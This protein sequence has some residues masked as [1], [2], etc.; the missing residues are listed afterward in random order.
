MGNTNLSLEREESPGVPARAAK[1]V[2][3][4]FRTFA[5]LVGT[6][7]V[8]GFSLLP[9]SA[10]LVALPAVAPG[11]A[12][13]TDTVKPVRS[14]WGRAARRLLAG[15]AGAAVLVALLAFAIELVSHFPLPTGGQMGT[16]AKKVL[17]YS[18]ADFV[19]NDPKPADRPPLKGALDRRDAA[20]KV[21]VS[22]DLDSATRQKAQAD[23]A[24]A[25]A[26]ITKWG[27]EPANEWMAPAATLKE[28][29]AL[30]EGGEAVKR[31]AL[32]DAAAER[33]SEITKRWLPAEELLLRQVT[34]RKAA[35]RPNLNPRDKTEAEDKLR[36]VDA[37]LAART[38]NSPR[39]RLL[40]DPQL[41]PILGAPLWTLLPPTLVD[42]WPFVLLVVYGTDLVLLLLIGKVPL[43]Y[44]FRYLWVRRRDTALTAVAFTVVVALVVVLLAF[45]NGMYKLNETTGVPGNVLV[46]SEGSTDELFSNLARGGDIDNVAN[47]VVTADRQGKPL[48]PGGRGVGVARAAV[49]PDGNLVRLPADT[50][51]DKPGA[52]PLMS[53]ESYVVLNQ[54]IPTKPNEPPKRRFI[55]LRA[56]RDAKVGALVHNIELEPGGKWFTPNSVEPGEKAPDGLEYL[57]CCVGEGAAGTLAEDAGKGRLAVGDTFE[58]GD[59]WWKVVG[60][61]KT[62]GTTY[63]SE[64]WTGIDNSVVRSSGKGDKYTTLVL[65]MADETDESAKAMSY[66]LTE[67]YEQAKLKAFAEPDY[68]KELTKTNEQFLT[69]IVLMAVIMAVGGIFGVMNTMF[70]SIAARIK[71]VGVLRILG[72]KRW[73]ILISFMI[74]SLAIAFA[75]GLLGCLIGYCANGFEAASTLSGGQGGGKS[76]TLTMQVDFT[77][78]ATGLLFTLVMGRLGGLVPALSAMRMEILESL[79]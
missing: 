26:E 25:N 4:F 20:R 56:F 50:P 74:E 47:V 64:I 5:R 19:P 18:V 62:R 45:V 33:V 51:R 15:L 21:L 9:L 58:L 17:G 75:G 79:R 23:L 13:L 60:L 76:V 8:I 7:F 65:R 69:A 12:V 30:P 29:R 46:M 67:V 42:R 40:R 27:T 61:M 44:N 57:Q 11:E 31:L 41:K 36:E 43:A 55:Q 72:F 37:E 34:L 35:R 10:L 53:Y 70:A 68:Y 1:A 24:A 28:Y 63:G 52:I 16:L 2:A 77:I 78:V 32:E 39:L 54:A 14:W 59:R 48:G 38:P 71:E 22:P 6:L 3:G 66:Y 49:G 73:Q